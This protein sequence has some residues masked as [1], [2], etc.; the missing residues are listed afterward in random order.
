MACATLSVNFGAAFFWALTVVI[1]A[2]VALFT[3]QGSRIYHDHLREKERQRS[4]AAIISYNYQPLA[5][6]PKL[7]RTDP[8]LTR[9]RIKRP[10]E[11]PPVNPEDLPG[12][13]NMGQ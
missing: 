6:R 4:Q 3:W 2:V 8:A 12:W 1:C 13:R 11:R 10:E 9:L 7:V 5:E